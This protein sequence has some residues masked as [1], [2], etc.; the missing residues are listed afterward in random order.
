M[1][2]WTQAL[3]CLSN[4]KCPDDRPDDGFYLKPLEE[5]VRPSDS[6]LDQ[7]SGDKNKLLSM[8]DN[9]FSKVPVINLGGA[10]NFT[11]NLILGRTRNLLFGLL[12]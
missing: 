12:V 9:K 3:T 1:Y 8:A 11:I 7:V 6:N 5:S 2:S 4:A 10:T